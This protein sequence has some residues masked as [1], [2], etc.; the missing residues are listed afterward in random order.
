MQLI[1]ERCYY[2]TYSECCTCKLHSQ[3]CTNI[4][5]NPH[6]FWPLLDFNKDIY[7]LLL[8]PCWDILWFCQVLL[9]FWRHF[10]S[11]CIAAVQ[12]NVSFLCCNPVSWCW[13][14]EMDMLNWSL[15]WLSSPL[16]QVADSHAGSSETRRTNHCHPCWPEWAAT[17]RYRAAILYLLVCFGATIVNGY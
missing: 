9:F 4:T 16:M 3:L 1:E 8:A 10:H 6:I 17:L 5:A 11:L 7:L 15:G 14:S 2:C 12:D 13:L